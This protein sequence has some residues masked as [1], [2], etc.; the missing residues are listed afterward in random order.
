MVSGIIYLRYHTY[1]MT[2]ESLTYFPNPINGGVDKI[3]AIAKTV[4]ILL[5][6][7]IE[8]CIGVCQDRWS[9]TTDKYRIIAIP[10]IVNNDIIPVENILYKVFNP[11][12]IITFLNLLM[13]TVFF[14][15]LTHK[16]MNESLEWTKECI[17]YRRTMHA[18]YDIQWNAESRYWKLS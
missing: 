13:S 5:E 9:K 7:Q 6:Y 3:N 18:A 11:I 15:M 8:C 10:V 4:Q 12:F 16:S 17:F 14:K 2:D 1:H